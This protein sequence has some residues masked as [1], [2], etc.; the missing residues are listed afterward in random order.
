MK[1]KLLWA[2]LALGW[3]VATSLVVLLWIWV[4]VIWALSGLD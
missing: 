4:F 1:K 3:F 2:V